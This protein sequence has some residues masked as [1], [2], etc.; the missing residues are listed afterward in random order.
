MSDI[1]SEKPTDPSESALLLDHNYDGIQELDHP[2]PRW[3]LMTFIGTIVF[4]IVYVSY[5]WLGPGLSSKQLLDIAMKDLEARRPKETA[6]VI[7]ESDMKKSAGSEDPL[8]LGAKVFTS[9]CA[10]CH[11]AN[12]Q[13]VI[14]PNLTD[15]FWIHGKGSL[16]DIAKVVHDGVLDKGMPAWAEVISPEEL[17]DVVLYV[18]SV[19]GT[20]PPN[21]KAPQGHPL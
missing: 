1:K 5:Y 10:P 7:T 8:K 2:L 17:K 21:P 18:K 16:S 20:H 3:W 4:S 9:R 14:G 13:G 15:E 19:A 12:A 11:G 6:V